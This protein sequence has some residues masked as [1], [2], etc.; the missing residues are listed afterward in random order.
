VIV[1]LQSTTAENVEAAR[2]D[3]EALVVGWG[4]EVAVAPSTVRGTSGD[5][6]DDETQLD[7]VSV[8]AMVLSIPS[9][10]LAVADQ[11]NRIHNRR[12]AQQLIDRANQLA[13]RQVTVYLV[14]DDRPIDLTA[15]G[16]DQL[17]S[18][19]ANETHQGERTEP[20]TPSTHP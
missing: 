2:R 12:R 3:L 4:H 1:Y 15:A 5:T 13:D 11:A 10:A 14:S 20:P 9:A 19:A 16:A 17:L 8:T 7:P 18:L 6:R